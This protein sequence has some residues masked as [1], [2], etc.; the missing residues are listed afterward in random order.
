MTTIDTVGIGA[1]LRYGID[2]SKLDPALARRVWELA[3][4]NATFDFLER[5]VAQHHGRLRWAAHAV[6]RGWC[7]D[8]TVNGLLGTYRLHLL[9]AGQWRSLLG[10]KG[11]RLL[12]VG[13]GAG[14]VTAELARSFDDVMA[15]ETS[16]S[17]VHRL[18]TAGIP[19]VRCDVTTAPVPEGP[20][21]AISLLNVLDRCARPRTMLTKL[22]NALGAGGRFIASMP[23]PYDPAHLSGPRV[24]E[25]AERL[26]LGCG[27]WEAQAQ[28]LVEQ[29]LEPAGLEVETLSRAPYLSE[30]D[31]SVPFYELDAVI[32][33]CRRAA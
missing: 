28:S 12:D 20:H 9:S 32:V 33:V 29:V 25:P 16:A 26:P 30:G 4:D 11:G 6:L 19:A 27:T 17:L 24:Y 14:D 31:R 8:F 15:V 10:G 1:Q 22:V 21:D 2:R 7:S 3:P 5:Q 13:A 23:L 18:K